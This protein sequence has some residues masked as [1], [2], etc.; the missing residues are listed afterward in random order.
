MA[1]LGDATAM[2]AENTC[3][4][5]DLYTSDK[6]TREVPPSTAEAGGDEAT[7]SPAMSIA[8]ACSKKGTLSSSEDET[9]N[10]VTPLGEG[11][12]TKPTDKAFLASMFTGL[13]ETARKRQQHT[14]GHLTQKVEEMVLDDDCIKS[15]A[16]YLVKTP[17]PTGA[18]LAWQPASDRRPLVACTGNPWDDDGPDESIGSNEPPQENPP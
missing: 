2:S 13:T 14:I 4:I 3:N 16:G 6:C 5:V 15:T 7:G 12:G 10:N 18:S 9:S 1:A 11:I 17:G 8:Q